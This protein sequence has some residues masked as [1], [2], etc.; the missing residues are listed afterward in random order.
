MTDSHG[1]LAEELRLLVET[2]LERIEPSLR[3]AA[4]GEGIPEWSS[5]SWCPL[6]AVVALVRGEHHEVVAALAEHGAFLE[7]SP[8]HPP[9]DHSP[10]P[11]PTRAW[12]ARTPRRR[13]QARARTL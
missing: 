9:L 8:H 6:C 5:C 7:V 3:R 4:T 10:S 1:E 2:V 12:H 11:W 13:R